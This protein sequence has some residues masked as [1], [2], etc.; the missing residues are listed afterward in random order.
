MFRRVLR[1]PSKH[2]RFTSQLFLTRKSALI[3]LLQDLGGG[4][5]AQNTFPTFILLDSVD[6][7]PAAVVVLQST[8]LAPNACFLVG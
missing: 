1:Q 8:I 3:T 4:G 6:T 7:S 5:K 2:S